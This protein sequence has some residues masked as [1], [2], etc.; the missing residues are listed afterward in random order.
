MSALHLSMLKLS[1]RILKASPYRNE[2]SVQPATAMAIIQP[3]LTVCLQIASPIKH[4]ELAKHSVML[5][6]KGML[7]SLA[8]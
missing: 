7:P 4:R 3:R 5:A 2:L 6:A 8:C 1:G